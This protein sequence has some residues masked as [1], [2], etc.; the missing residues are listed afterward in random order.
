MMSGPWDCGFPG[1]STCDPSLG[2]IKAPD[3]ARR[4]DFNKKGL[5]IAPALRGELQQASSG[6]PRAAQGTTS[7]GGLPSSLGGGHF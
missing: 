6:V 2:I 4:P 7:R 3:A 5:A 1:P